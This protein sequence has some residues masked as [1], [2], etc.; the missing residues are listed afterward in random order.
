MSK[1]ALRNSKLSAGT[2]LDHGLIIFSY[3]LMQFFYIII[4]CN[5]QIFFSFKHN[6]NEQSPEPC[7]GTIDLTNFHVTDGNYTKRKNVFR[8]SS[9]NYPLT[10]SSSA[11]NSSTTTPT[12][13]SLCGFERELL[14]QAQSPQDMAQW[15]GNLKTVCRNSTQNSTVSLLGVEVV[16]PT[17]S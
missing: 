12:S 5:L 14:I 17:C 8:L 7:G 13:S 15:I 3:I 11:Q 16:Y 4:L 6:D 1:W 2:L 10:A 9:A